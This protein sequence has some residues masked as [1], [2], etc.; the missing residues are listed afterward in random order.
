MEHA[1]REAGFVEIRRREFAPDLDSKVR[2][3][4][5]LYVSAVKPLNIT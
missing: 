4:G 1:L 2:E 3:S 5:T